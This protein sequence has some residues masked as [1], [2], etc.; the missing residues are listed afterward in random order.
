MAGQ[1]PKILIIYTGGTIGMVQ[2]ASTGALVPFDFKHLIENAPKINQLGYRLDHIR[3]EPPIDSSNMNPQHWQQI[4]GMVEKNYTEYDGFLILHGTDTMAYTASALSFMLP[5]IA[6]PVIVTGSQLP[7]GD[8]RQDGTEN[9]I[10]ALEVAAATDKDTGKP[11]VQE[12]A[13]SFARHLWRGN[14]STKVSSTNFE[15]FKSF[16]YPPLAEMNLHISFNTDLLLRPES[17]DPFTA[18]PQMDDAVSV[19]FI[20]PGITKDVLQAQLDVPGIK[21]VVLRTFGA[22]NAPTE[23]WFTDALAD[24]VK[25]GKV[26]VNVTQ[27][28]A[29]GVEQKRY[30]TG[31]AMA[32][33]GVT[34]GYGMTC[35]A[36]LTKMMHLFGKG[37][38]PE[39]V[40]EKMQISLAGEL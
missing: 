20:Y 28:P 6:K 39:E 1:Q 15:A 40:A 26:I 23:K 13:I 21:G 30:A 18:E 31:D 4:C 22:G 11:M 25:S 2:D 10:T 7:I 38:S 35:E 3:F 32:D 19:V 8:T 5:E 33:A 9:L 12:V 27:C 36:A 17:T 14:R 16:N 34:S 37:M 29:G 24:A